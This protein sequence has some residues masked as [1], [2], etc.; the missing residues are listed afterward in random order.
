[1][2]IIKLLADFP[3]YSARKVRRLAKQISLV[4]RLSEMVALGQETGVLKGIEADLLE[5][6]LL[7]AKTE[8]QL[9]DDLAHPDLQ[10]KV[11]EWWGHRT[12]LPNTL[13]E[14]HD[15][16]NDM[17]DQWKQMAENMG[18]REFQDPEVLLERAKWAAP[19]Q[20]TSLQH[21]NVCPTAAA[22]KAVDLV[23]DWVNQMNGP[24]PGHVIPSTN[25]VRNKCNDIINGQSFY[26]DRIIIPAKPY[27][28]DSLPLDKPE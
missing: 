14:A 6:N 3:N 24:M 26:T 12:E 11:R 18:F 16:I 23:F 25:E 5:F 15:W 2:S 4:Q 1:M 10:P 9:N 8:E 7:Q 19:E 17:L 27:P 20:G 22:R 28:Q 13:E 21:R